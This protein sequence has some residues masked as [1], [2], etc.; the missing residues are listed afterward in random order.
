MCSLCKSL[1]LIRFCQEIYELK[2]DVDPM[3]CTSI[4]RFDTGTDA[5][6]NCSL[7][8]CGNNYI[9]ACSQEDRCHLYSL[10]YKVT[11]ASE[12]EP[13]GNFSLYEI[14]VDYVFISF[15]FHCIFLN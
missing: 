5:I 1:S 2:Y 8:Y 7:T 14:C 6:M 9:L 15:L 4:H 10:K 13:G 3:A 11:Y 12:H